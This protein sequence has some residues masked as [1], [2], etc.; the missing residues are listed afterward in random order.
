MDISEQ[1]LNC[2]WPEDWELVFFKVIAAVTPDKLRK[3]GINTE[4]WTEVME[5]ESHRA[6]CVVKM[7]ETYNSVL[8][9]S[10][11][12]DNLDTI[13]LNTIES[14]VRWMS[15]VFHHRKQKRHSGEFYSSHLWGA[16][17]KAINHGFTELR[18]A[19]IAMAHDTLEDINGLTPENL[20]LD[21]YEEMGLTDKTGIKQRS[22]EVI[23]CVQSLTKP[24]I[25]DVDERN[26]QYLYQLIKI[27]ETDAASLIVKLFDR[28]HNLSTLDGHLTEQKKKE[29]AKES[30]E[31]F[32]PIAHKLALYWLE[33]EMARLALARVNP[34][35]IDNYDRRIWGSINEVS[36]KEKRWASVKELLERSIPEIESIKLLPHRLVDYLKHADPT[37][38]HER[39]TLSDLNL[40]ED[41]DPMVDIEICINNENPFEVVAKIQTLFRN[42]EWKVKQYRGGEVLA[43]TYG[44]QF[45]D[46]GYKAVFRVDTKSSFIMKK[47][48][49]FQKINNFEPPSYV[50]EDARSLLQEVERTGEDIRIAARRSLLHRSIKINYWVSW[51]GW[52]E[53]YI[54]KGINCREFLVKVVGEENIAKYKLIVEKEVLTNRFTN[55]AYPL[56]L[57]E[58][59]PQDHVVIIKE[60]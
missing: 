37:I 39:L 35:L 27:L 45:L 54:K 58:T 24:K 15:C 25:D 22:E 7:I 43:R 41:H 34:D 26:K 6:G 33:E 11:N 18:I 51:Q 40:P 50:A 13:R 5:R 9:F 56:G 48:G 23:K 19:D 53:I 2:S 32:I 52:G 36:K 57:D 16:T 17:E 4:E 12:K 46:F 8:G 59:I 60:I 38:L 20:F 14:F 21:L 1:K 10:N 28:W 29:I 3:L 55:N 44:P 31:V 49:V 42:Q 30:L 47:R